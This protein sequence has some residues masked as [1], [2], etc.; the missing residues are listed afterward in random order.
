MAIVPLVL[1]H[2]ALGVVTVTFTESG[3]DVIVS[4]DGTLE[5][6]PA[7]PAF[8]FSTPAQGGIVENK[9][10]SSRQGTSAYATNGGTASGSGLLS[11]N[12]VPVESGDV[13]YFGFC[14][15]YTSPSP[16]DRG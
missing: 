16:R 12:H 15:L 13:G 4:F 5:I 8:A 9:G 10:I 3:P 1:S 11:V 2:S 6:D 14:L 7:L